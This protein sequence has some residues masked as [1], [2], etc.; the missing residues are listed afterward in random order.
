MVSRLEP[1]GFIL[2]LFLVF[3][4]DIWGVVLAPLIN[5]LVVILAGSH[6]GMVNQAMTFLFGH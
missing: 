2:I 3:F 6:V 4:T 5:G 1:F